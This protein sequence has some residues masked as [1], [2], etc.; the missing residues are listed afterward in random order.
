K[1]RAASDEEP[2]RPKA[3][4]GATGAAPARAG[5]VSGQNGLG[6]GSEL[7]PSGLD[8]VESGLQIARVDRQRR[9]DLD[10][11]VLGSRGLKEQAVVERIGGDLLGHLGVL[12]AETGQQSAAADRGALGLLDDRVEAL[13]QLG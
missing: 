4:A 6:G 13:V 10:D 3:R 8:D 11:L 1:G 7:E 5:G 9:H 12:E 2:I